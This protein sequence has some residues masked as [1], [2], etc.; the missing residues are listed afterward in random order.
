MRKWVCLV[1]MLPVCLSGCRREPLTD[2]VLF[3]ENYNLAAKE[4]IRETDACLRSNNE[5]L[6]FAGEALVRLMLNEDG[7]VHTAV[8]TGETADETAAVC[9]TAFT[10]LAN[11]L[12]ED[13]PQSLARLCSQRKTAVQT[14]QTKR[15]FY[16]VYCDGKTVTA[17]QVNLLLSS[18]PDLP[19]LRPSESE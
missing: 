8:V 12:S 10:V 1:L 6:L 19:T 3:C 17:V 7:A 5:I 16:A 11:P 9:E 2:P 14:L 13:V 4:P 18:I 15:F